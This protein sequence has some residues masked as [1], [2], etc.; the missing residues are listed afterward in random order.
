MS[1]YFSDLKNILLVRFSSKVSDISS[2]LITSTC[3]CR[4]TSGI[5]EQ[6]SEKDAEHQLKTKRNK[7]AFCKKSKL[8]KKT[9][10]IDQRSDLWPRGPAHAYYYVWFY[11]SSHVFLCC[12]YKYS[13]SFLILLKFFIFHH[14]SFIFL[15][16]IYV[17]ILHIYKYVFDWL[18]DGPRL[19]SRPI[20]S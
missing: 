4:A 6:E 8:L 17:F 19:R 1:F 10:K 15:N 5:I 9:Q 12:I 3:G 13:S 18:I 16:F 20:I 14:N 11:T 2:I 7:S